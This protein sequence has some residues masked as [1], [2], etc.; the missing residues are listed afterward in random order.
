MPVYIYSC[1]GELPNSVADRNDCPEC[2]N[3]D[4]YDFGETINSG[5]KQRHGL[6]WSVEG[7]RNY[8]D[9]GAGRWFGS[10]EDRKAWL[11][12]NNYR[13]AKNAS[14]AETW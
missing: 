13:P 12:A 1:C 3:K 4:A 6:K 7:E 14:M 9:E 11:R 10:S 8:Y 2:G 5:I